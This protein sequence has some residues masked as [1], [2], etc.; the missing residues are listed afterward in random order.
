MI[1]P[2]FEHDIDLILW[3]NDLLNNLKDNDNSKNIVEL[4]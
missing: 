3:Y 2:Y 1:R 4:S